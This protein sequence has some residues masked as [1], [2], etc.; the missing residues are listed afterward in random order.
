M[1]RRFEYEPDKEL[2]VWTV[3]ED[4]ARYFFG[5]PLTAPVRVVKEAPETEDERQRYRPD[6]K[7]YA[8][9]PVVNVRID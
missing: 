9:T 1:R 2:F 5:Q 7:L 6:A 3:G 8:V 4:E